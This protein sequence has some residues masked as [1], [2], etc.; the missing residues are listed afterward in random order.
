MSSHNLKE[1]A[2]KGIAWSLIE[3]LLTQLITF[4]VVILLA[5]E[6][7]PSD[8]GLVGMLAIFLAVAD[9][10]INSGFSSALIQKQNRS[11]ID[12]S[13]VFYLNMGISIFIYISLFI[14]APIISD[15]YKAPELTELS[16]VLFL[17]LIINALCLVPNTILTVELKFKTKSK[18]NVIALVISSIFAI[19]GGLNGFGVW[20]IVLQSIIRSL[21]TLFLLCIFCKWL[22]LFVF[23]IDSF[24]KLF[25]FGS[26]LLIA[27]LVATIVNNLYGL[28]IGRYFN[29]Q[30]VGYFM[31]GQRIT[32]IISGTISKVLQGVTYPI[33]ASVQED[34]VRLISIYKRVIGMTVFITFPTMIGLALIAESF[35]ILL[36][37]E[38]WLQTVPIIQWL[39]LAT[40]F[41]PISALNMN[42][43]IATGRSDLFLKVDLSKLPINLILLFITVPFGIEVVAMGQVV[44][45]MLAFFINTYYPGK[46]Y[47]Y[48]PVEQLKDM[49]P[50]LVSTTI[51]ALVLW[52][53][54]IDDPLHHIICSIIVG[55]IIY[56]FFTF[57]FKVSA[58]AD[59]L[60]IY[61]D[62]RKTSSHTNA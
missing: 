41:M 49:L 25:N 34:R 1:K 45:R 28:L 20:T 58:L 42:I 7:S 17:I 16:R 14:T 13:T 24:R 50:I 60:N 6:L 35:V 12:Y 15:F 46:L 55:P 37:T 36:L 43:L 44:S 40:M 11:E 56:L 29:A 39:C 59:L 30:S 8:F 19:W 53:I 4:G 5:R 33:M 3:K 26:K 47:G 54:Q 51:M 18:V 52:I 9:S 23:S 62:A 21:S 38:K 32:T 10:L 57:L 2:I 27:G 61:N 48:G 31:Q 22:P